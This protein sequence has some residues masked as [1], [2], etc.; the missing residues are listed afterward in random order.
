MQ[1]IEPDGT[2]VAKS[3]SSRITLADLPPSSRNTFFSVSAPL[4]MM[5][6]PVAVEPVKLTMS[7]RGSDVSISPTV[8]ASPDVTTFSTPGGMSVCSAAR[9]PMNVALHGVSGAGLRITVFPVASAWASL[10]IETSNGKFHGTMAPTTPT[11]SFQIRRWSGSPVWPGASG[12]SVSQ[13]NS[14]MSLA[15]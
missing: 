11:G 4:A 15:G 14:S 2:A 1:I 6:R 9:R 10:L 7:T 8:A 3:A 12:S 13:A 5:R